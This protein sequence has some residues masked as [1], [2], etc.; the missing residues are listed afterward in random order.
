MRRPAKE[1]APR[2]HR[3][4]W[5]AARRLVAPSV[6]MALA[7]TPSMA[8]GQDGSDQ[9]VDDPSYDDRGRQRATP[10]TRAA[11]R[12][13]TPPEVL[14]SAKAEH[15]PAAREA[16]VEGVVVVRL[17]IDAHGTVT[18]V[19]VEEGPGGGW[20]FEQAA[21]TAARGLSFRPAK[22]ADG[23]PFASI[24]RFR[25]TFALEDDAPP[26]A[27][28]GRFVGRV[29]IAGLDEP[30]AGATLT[31]VGPL[32]SPPTEG[33]EVPTRRVRS[34]LRGGFAFDGLDPGDYRLR[35]GAEGHEV[36]EIVETV[37]AS[38]ELDATYRLTPVVEGGALVVTT[39]G[40]RPAR[41]VTRRTLERREIE[42]VPGTN[43]DA[44]RAIQNLPGVART[45]GFLGALIVRGSAPFD[46]QTFVDGVYVPLI[47]HFGGLSSVIPTELLNKIDFYPG[48]YSA[49]YGR[50]L[51]GVVDVGIR[52]PRSDGLH[53]MVQVDLIDAR[54]ILEGPVPNLPG[55][56]FAFAGRRSWLDAW[57]GPVLESAGAGVATAPRY[58]DYQFLA[59]R[60]WDTSKLRLSLYGSDDRLEILVGEPAPG[61]PA[62]SGN[63]GFA[64][65]WQRL[66]A[67]WTVEPRVGER[68]ETQ[69][70]LGRDRI[71]VGLGGLFFELEG[72]TIFARTEYSRPLS[73]TTRVNAGVDLQS[74]SVEVTA[75]IPAPQ[76]PGQPDNQPFSTRNTVTTDQRLNVFL[77]AGYVELEVTPVAR[78]RIVPGLR[79]DYDG[80]T[81]T[82][83]LSPRFNTRFDIVPD[84]P[85][86]TVKGGVGVFTQPPQPQQSNL[87]LGTQGL[88]SERAIQWGLGVEQE[89]TT[90]IHASGEGFLK[91]IDDA[92]VGAT[93]L[94]RAGVD[95]TNDGIRTVFGGELL[96]KYEPDERFFGWLAYTL[97]RAV[98]R[99][100]PGAETVPLPWDQ[101]H[102]L[103]VLGSYRFG[104]GWEAGLRFRLVS[105]NRVDAAVCNAAE[106]ACD[107]NRIN[108]L[109]H[110]ASGAYTPIRFG[111]DN[112][113]QLPLFHQLDLRVDKRWDFESWRLRAYLDV[114][115]VYNNRN[116][117]GLSYD[118]RFS[119][120][121]F[122]TGI[123]ILPSVGIRAEF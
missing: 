34:D 122:V 10:S 77:P 111:G 33:G 59:E 46:S 60:A 61:E 36:L 43:G 37:S 115:N 12:S 101:T 118:F 15:P 44:L 28:L 58:Y 68:V 31:L 64:T 19:E 25:F 110:A 21:V 39:V 51:G 98:R 114:Q 91:Q 78:W 3:G 38:G 47:Y 14:Q 69:L 113:E 66:Q 97:S 83:D 116:V 53:G 79:V 123:P 96:L 94:S 95:Y 35:I 92:V 30:L 74:S 32:D 17:T 106:Q 112:A 105:G 119:A 6:V 81:E 82:A 56:T 26:P 65:V 11:P 104:G 108:A 90:Q 70:A 109:F 100:A 89:I 76:A 86:T 45:P 84:F 85:K 50:A 57:L 40:D 52:S 13:V 41:E 42:R 62:L 29:R 75:R 102:N 93:S 9:R 120:R 117:E 18:H 103:V 48:N 7:A 54:V 8:W 24:I 80:A 22:R 1:T 67:G 4:T 63:F 2:A 55:W 71:G 5:A 87:P 99:D 20:G 27:A 107:P 23:T 72:H 73:R 16:G 49:R 88:R 121:Q